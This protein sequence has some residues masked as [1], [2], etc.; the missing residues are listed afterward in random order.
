MKNTKLILLG[1]VTSLTLFG[2]VRKPYRAVNTTLAG[3]VKA[4]GFQP[5][6]VPNDA[7]G[8]M[9]L[10]TF[11]R[12]SETIVGMQDECFAE[13]PAIKT[14]KLA[15]PTWERTATSTHELS[16]ALAESVVEGLDLSFLFRDERVRKVK[17]EMK[18]PTMLF[19]SEITARS[20]VNSA[21]DQCKD[22]AVSKQNVLI[23]AVLASDGISIQ[24]EGEGNQRVKLQAQYAELG[25]LSAERKRDLIDKGTLV[26]N[27]QRLFYGYRPFDAKKTAGLEKDLLSLVPLQGSLAFERVALAKK[28]SPQ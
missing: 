11:T 23:H 9:S 20:Q 2:C 5:Y 13:M 24:L 8:P 22:A 7:M 21:K 19:V 12:N 14:A 18:N 10:V 16:A 27:N 6:S 28:S 4:N 1:L 15:L 3:F 25:N 26:V 17:M